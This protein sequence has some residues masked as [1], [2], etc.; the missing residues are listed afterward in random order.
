MSRYL[1]PL[2]DELTD[3]QRELYR[4]ITDGPRKQQASLVPVTDADGRLLG[5]FAL[6]TIAPTIGQAVQAVGA[7]LRFAGA[8]SA[9][10]RE[11]AIL[12]V[13]VHHGSDFEWFAHVDAAR[14]AGLSPAQLRALQQREIPA[15]LDA[16]EAVVHRVVCEL[17]ADGRLSDTSYAEAVTSLGAAGIAECIWLIGYYSMLQLALAAFDPVV[18]S[19]VVG[20]VTRPV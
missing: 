6:M 18:P 4:S 1:A 2:P 5:P 12:T 3:R 8:F 13:A 17:L 16:Q 20:A 7:A 10:T 9:R 15:D 14:E 19:A 11:L